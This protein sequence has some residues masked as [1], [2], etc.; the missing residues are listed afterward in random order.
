MS[1]RRTH[2]TA[3]IFLLLFVLLAGCQPVFEA[4]PVTPPDVGPIRLG[5]S[6]GQTFI[7]DRSGLTAMS[8]WLEPE[9]GA[10]GTLSLEL[11][12]RPNASEALTVSS[13]EVTDIEGPGYRRFSFSPIPESRG[14]YLYARLSFDGEGEVSVGIEPQDAYLDGS[15][16]VDDVSFPAQMTFT[17][18]NAPFYAA[19]DWL[20]WTVSGVVQ[21]TVLLFLFILPGWAILV[22]SR[23]LGVD[24]GLTHWGEWL[25]VAAGFSLA[26]YPLLILWTHYVG[27][28]LG[29]VYAWLPAAAAAAVLVAEYRP[30][31]VSFAGLRS[32]VGAWRASSAFWPDMTLGIVLAALAFSRLLPLRSLFLPLWD[33]S[34]QHATIVQLLL[35]RGGLFSS[36]QP[37]AAYST[38][39]TQFGF[40]SLTA[41]WGWLT[42]LDGPRATLVAGQIINVLAVVTL[43]PLAYRFKGI[44]AGV[45]SVAVAGM[46]TESPAFYANWGRYPQ[47]AGLALLPV[48]LWAVWVAGDRAGEWRKD[49]GR[50]L[51]AAVLLTA[52]ALCY[53]RAVFHYAA[54]IAAAL[55][56]W[57]MGR[58]LLRWQLWLVLLLVFVLVG[59]L[60]LP[61]LQNISEGYD[62]V[63]SPGGGR[64]THQ[65]TSLLEVMAHNAIAMLAQNWSMEVLAAI[66]VSAA[67]ALW[68]GWRFVLPL[69]WL[70][71][72]LVLPAA[73]PLGL[74]GTWMIQEF[75]ISTSLYLP[76]TLIAAVGLA[77]LIDFARGLKQSSRH[78]G[79]P[80]VSLA[81]VGVSLVRAPAVAA[82]I[83][84]QES[85]LIGYPDLRAAEW[86]NRSVPQDAIF[87]I[88]GIVYPG[89]SVVGGDGG[90]WLPL[91]TQR[92]TT[93]PPQ[94]ALL[95]EKAD[96]PGYK[97]AVNQL[98]P[99][100][101]AHGPDSVIGK[102]AICDFPFPITHVYL[103]QRRGMVDAWFLPEYQVDRPMLR[104]EDIIRDSAFHLLY[105]QDTVWIFDFD[106]SVC[107]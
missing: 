72:L 98:V 12:E 61:W 84:R 94:Y 18:S 31:C 10:R 69:A 64:N 28:H 14:W 13:L 4:P 82:L 9:E 39:S 68:A 33:D 37:Y 7:C 50:V 101:L 43:F 93:I 63:S 107:E 16:Y 30:W 105:Q 25:A 96:L 62:L 104:P 1:F 86:I 59:V 57:W 27:L 20:Y 49:A 41:V 6:V 46:I 2:I 81:V 40:H 83:D 80:L 65:I 95:A 8:V 19:V 71:F 29:A 78:W 36:W 56:S 3:A 88:N 11:L 22:L 35:E 34:V 24:W 85:D 45:A 106:R 102:K 70:G 60:M 21:L 73:R 91:L 52:T 23:R 97:A 44:W 75:T 58:R 66:V 76:M 26:V 42:G 90:W 17:L 54:F 100:L 51:L 89:G 47:L 15:F 48:A 103:G 38:L 55:V 99:T 79:L 74:P 87:L 53:Y 5:E 92:R 67:V 32:R 77:A